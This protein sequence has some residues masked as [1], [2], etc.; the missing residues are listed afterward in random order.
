MGWWIRKKETPT[1]G[2]KGIMVYPG[3]KVQFGVNRSDA[4]LRYKYFDVAGT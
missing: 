3:N 2:T 4:P 1:V